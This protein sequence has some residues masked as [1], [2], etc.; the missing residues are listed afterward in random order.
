[1][2][3]VFTLVIGAVVGAGLGGA[4]LAWVGWPAGRSRRG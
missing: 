1:M 4:V 2:D 3:D